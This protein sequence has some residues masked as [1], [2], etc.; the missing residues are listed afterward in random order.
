MA[1]IKSGYLSI[2]LNHNLHTGFRNVSFRFCLVSFS[3]Y[4]ESI[5]L[6]HCDCQLVKDK[7]LNLTGCNILNMFFT[8]YYLPFIRYNIV[9]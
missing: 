1:R 5:A 4:A 3:L 9:Y 7:N 2:N 8:T 6:P